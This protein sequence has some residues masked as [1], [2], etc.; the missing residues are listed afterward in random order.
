MF[1]QQPKK[2][3]TKH[4]ASL[5]FSRFLTTLLKLKNEHSPG[6][7]GHCYA[8]LFMQ[9]T[10]PLRQHTLHSSWRIKIKE[11]TRTR[12]QSRQQ[13]TS[14]LLQCFRRS[15]G[16]KTINK[17]TTVRANGNA[18]TFSNSC[19]AALDSSLFIQPTEECCPELAHYPTAKVLWEC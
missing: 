1:I 18:S 8:W 10:I 6:K 15:R 9:K 4:K 11:M 7:K 19:S 17:A 12:A 3:Q 16:G 13:H 2:P 5:K 14:S